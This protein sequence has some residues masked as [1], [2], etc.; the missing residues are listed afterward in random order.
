[1]LDPF[2]GQD[3]R[4]ELSYRVEPSS[5]L[6]ID[7]SDF[8]D[9]AGAPNPEPASLSSFA[10]GTAP[11]S[12]PTSTVGQVPYT[13]WYRVWERTSL[14]DFKM[15]MYILPFVL[16]VVAVHLWGT[17]TNRNK[18]KQWIKAHGPVLQQEF[19]QVGFVRPQ[20]SVD[21]LGS[22]GLEHPDNWIREKKADEYQSYATGR[23]NIAFVDM[24]LTLLKRYNP[25]MRLGEVLM[26]LFFE[27]MP[28]PEE[29]LEATSYAFD[30]KEAQV[31]PGFG[32]GEEKK[33]VPN[34]NF[35]GF[36][37]A[38]VHKDL[39]KRLREDRYDLSLTSTKD[40]A[41]LPVWVTVMSENAEITEKLL[42]PE[43]IKAIHDAGDT[44]EALVVSDQPMD[45][46]KT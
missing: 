40:H 28:A 42:T 11:S 9:Y 31:A 44:F 10:T 13:Q 19:A 29:R 22:V 4:S 12:A 24:K 7:V 16:L 43:L 37:W 25:L 14:E 15:E 32:K 39:M 26:G 21:D 27:S 5:K 33:S 23:Q 6:L 38:V 35:D 36:V 1:L 30:G 34:S 3:D 41:K 8:A 18:A 2:S 17:R 45:Q 20:A 46:P